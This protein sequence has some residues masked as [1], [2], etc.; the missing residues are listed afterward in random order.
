MFNQQVFCESYQS[1][2]PDVLIT[3]SSYSW[4][5]WFNLSIFTTNIYVTL[6]VISDIIYF[7]YKNDQTILLAIFIYK[8]SKNQATSSKRGMS[9]DLLPNIL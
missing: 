2:A 6:F 7:S 1:Y 5:I 9:Y 8:I 3:Q 4:I